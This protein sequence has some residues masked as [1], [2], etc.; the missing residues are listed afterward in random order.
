MKARILKPISIQ[1]GSDIHNPSG[2]RFVPLPVGE[3]VDME[4]SRG[5][6]CN[7]W[8]TFQGQRGKIDCGEIRNITRDGRVELL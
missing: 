2:G 1:V 4:D 3:V 5:M 7:V 8:V 6:S